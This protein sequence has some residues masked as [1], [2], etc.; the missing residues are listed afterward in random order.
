MS[1]GE[2]LVKIPRKKLIWYKRLEIIWWI[3]L[4][5]LAWSTTYVFT[6]LDKFV[7]CHCWWEAPP[8]VPNYYVEIKN[9]V[10]PKVQLP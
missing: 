7:E 1:S 8:G 10:I 5:I 6:H 9:P 3:I 4:I 2:D